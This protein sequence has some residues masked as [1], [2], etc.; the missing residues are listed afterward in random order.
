MFD[1]KNIQYIDDLKHSFIFLNDGTIKP[2]NEFADI[3]F[4]K[5]VAEIDRENL[6]QM[7]DV[8]GRLNNRDLG[9]TL[10]EIQNSIQ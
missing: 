2:I 6:K 3:Q 9:D 10:T 4:A 7:F 1:G 5:G 8:V